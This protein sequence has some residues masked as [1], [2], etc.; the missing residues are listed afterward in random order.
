MTDNNISMDLLFGKPIKVKED[1]FLTIPTVEE[2]A[3]SDN[4]SKY[5]SLFTATTRELFSS[6]QEVDK[7][8]KMF[9]TIWSMAF[10]EENGGDFLLGKIFGVDYPGSGLI[11]E[12][13]SYW[14]GLDIDGFQKLTNKKII[15]PKSEWI[16]DS[17]EF[18]RLSKLIKTVTCFEPS[19]HYTAPKNMNATRFKAWESILKGRLKE[20]QRN[21]RSLADKILILSVSMESYIPIEQIGKMSYFHFNKLYEVLA[22][23][24]A[25]KHR[26]DVKISPKFEADNK[27]IRHWKETFKITK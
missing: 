12:A 3:Y 4:F 10:D 16:I 23:K 14:T 17:K 21:K 15:Y 2:V 18:R 9:P 13:L 24:E 25:Y 20:A 11:M 7:L 19:T 1:I 26:W 22:E 8:E 6:Q 27:T 5:T